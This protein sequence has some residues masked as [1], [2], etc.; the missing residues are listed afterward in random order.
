ME[1]DLIE[2]TIADSLKTSSKARTIIRY[3]FISVVV[4][5]TLA[6]IYGYF[7]GGS[8]CSALVLG[9]SLGG[10]AVVFAIQHGPNPRTWWAAIWGT[11]VALNYDLRANISYEERIKLVQDIETWTK[12]EIPK[13]DVVKVNPWRYHFRRKDQAM[14]FKMTWL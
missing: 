14:L 2:I 8:L 7:L 10:F 11:E 3:I 9:L 6:A 1:T 4:F 5:N 13:D 12:T